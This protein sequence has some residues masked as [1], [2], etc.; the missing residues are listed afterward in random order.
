MAQ[1][2]VSSV[3]VEQVLAGGRGAFLTATGVRMKLDSHGR[4]LVIAK[5]TE[6]EYDQRTS[7]GG[8]VGSP[9]GSPISA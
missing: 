3:L 5:I 6:T 2:M 4:K 7:G 8:E 1:A 9:P